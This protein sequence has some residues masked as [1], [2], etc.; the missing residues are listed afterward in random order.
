[1]LPFSSAGTI[2][3]RIAY[4]YEAQQKE[5]PIIALAES[6]MRNFNRLRNPGTHLVDFIPLCMSPIGYILIRVT[7]FTMESIRS[8]ICPT[9]VPR[10]WLQ[11]NGLRGEATA[12]GECR[13]PIPI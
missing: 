12:S 7:G 11:E 9:V 6:A 4:G 1:M 3:I 13:S 5:D 8:K 2:I 10:G